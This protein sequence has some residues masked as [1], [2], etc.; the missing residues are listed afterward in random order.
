VYLDATLETVDDRTAAAL[1][2]ILATLADGRSLDPVLDDL[3]SRGFTEDETGLLESSAREL[4]RVDELFRPY[5]SPTLAADL[6]RRPHLAELG[7]TEREVTVLFAD[8]QGFTGY[9]ERVAPTVAIGMLNAY[10]AA[11]VPELLSEGATIERFAGDGVL[12]VFNAVGDQPDH[13]ERAARAAMGL[14]RS[15]T[16]LADANPGWPRFRA[17]LA[18]GRAAVGNVGTQEQRSFTAIGDTTNVAAR[19]QGL[20]RPGQAVVAASTAHQ[21]SRVDLVPLGS[22]EVKG[23]REP[24]EIFALVQK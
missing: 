17:G 8:L 22:V 4:R 5:V 14:L 9:A 10:W 20:A 2:A 6:E 24:I 19:L 21:L 13:A 23:R 18:T 1:R 7:G 3:R 15:S 16:T 12:A 11:A